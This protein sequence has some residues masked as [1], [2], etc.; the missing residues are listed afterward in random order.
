MREGLELGLRPGL[1]ESR[2]D[3]RVDAA[4]HVVVEQAREQVA[5][6]GHGIAAECLAI[7]AVQVEVEGN[8]GPVAAGAFRDRES[9][10]GGRN[11]EVSVFGI[12]RE[13]TLDRGLAIV[14]IEWGEKTQGRVVKPRVGPLAGFQALLLRESRGHD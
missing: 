8:D 6:G 2:L 3:E 13:R 11:R 9:L 10:P 7:E 4:T 14:S 1:C 5:I 12:A